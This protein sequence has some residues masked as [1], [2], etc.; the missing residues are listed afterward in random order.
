MFSPRNVGGGIKEMRRETKQN[1]TKKALA[2]MVQKS[3]SEGARMLY[4]DT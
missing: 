2:E 3:Q 1:K 4:G